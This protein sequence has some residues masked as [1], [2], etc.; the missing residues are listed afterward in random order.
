MLCES[1][2]ALIVLPRL[3]HKHISDKVVVVIC[4]GYYHL[5]DIGIEY[6][7][8]VIFLANTFGIWEL[9]ASVLA[10]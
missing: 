2:A 6:K 7:F 9:E 1:V 3:F 5:V 10:M 4:V 8:Q